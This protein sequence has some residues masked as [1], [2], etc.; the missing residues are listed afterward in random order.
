MG[1]NEKMVRENIEHHKEKGMVDE[2]VA[3]EAY[4]TAHME[5]DGERVATA[6]LRFF[7][8][9]ETYQLGREIENGEQ[10]IEDS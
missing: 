3:H 9:R 6:I 7:S 1:Y 2:D 5:H 8:D 4:K 10:S